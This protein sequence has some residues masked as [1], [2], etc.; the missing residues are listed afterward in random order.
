MLTSSQMITPN[1]QAYA[2]FRLDDNIL[3]LD[4]SYDRARIMIKLSSDWMPPLMLSSG[5]RIKLI[6]SSGWMITYTFSFGV[7]IWWIIA[8]IF[9]SSGWMLLFYEMLSSGYFITLDVII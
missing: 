5:W 9:L 1:V 7:I 8:L 2:I 6:L 3:L 4:W